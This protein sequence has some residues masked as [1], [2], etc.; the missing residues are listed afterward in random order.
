MAEVEHDEDLVERLQ[1][2]IHE[3]IVEN[4]PR[5][6]G[7]SVIRPTETLLALGGAWLITAVSGYG[8]AHRNM[9]T[10]RLDEIRDGIE[11]TLD[12]FDLAVRRQHD[13]GG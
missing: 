5:V 6:K 12:S 13:G 11:P 3:A 4:S 10:D 2:A 9:I 8:R 7:E 1:D